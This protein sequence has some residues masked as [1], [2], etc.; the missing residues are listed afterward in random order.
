MS[1]QPYADAESMVGVL[2]NMLIL[3]SDMGSYPQPNDECFA[4]LAIKAGLFEMC[5]KLLV[6]FG[7]SQGAKVVETMGYLLHGA[8]PSPCSR[9]L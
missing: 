7:N 8:R 2:Y 9:I 6:S 5:L 3:S 4:L 1:T